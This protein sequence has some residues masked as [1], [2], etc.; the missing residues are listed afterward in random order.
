VRRLTEGEKCLL[1]IARDTLRMS[2]AMVSV[3]GGPTKEYAREIILRLT[4]RKADE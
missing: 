4:G 2:D 1:R 3:M